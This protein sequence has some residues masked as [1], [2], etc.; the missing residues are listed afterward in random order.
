M[1]R[2]VFSIHN[3][4]VQWLVACLPCTADRAFELLDGRLKKPY[5]RRLLSDLE[6]QGVVEAE[7]L[8]GRILRGRRPLI[9]RLSPDWELDDA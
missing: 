9:Y 1:S 4:S 5:I 8:Q 3:P 2:G 7:V 6:S